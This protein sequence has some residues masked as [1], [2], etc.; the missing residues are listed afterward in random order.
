MAGMFSS[1]SSASYALQTHSRSVEQAG[2]NIANIN[3]PNYSRQRIVTGTIGTVASSTGVEAGPLV[4]LGVQQ[5]RDVYVDRQLLGELSYQ[6]SLETQDFRLRQALSNLGDSVD[7][8]SDALFVDDISQQGGGL[9]G[10]L[11]KFFN[12]FESLA[13]RPTDATT[14]QV[15]FQS[16]EALVDSFNRTDRRMELMQNELETQISVETT[17]FN[18]RISELEE[19]NREI[20]R[21]EL[22]LPGSALDLRD[23]RQ[24]KLEE[25][26]KYALVETV[27]APGDNGQISVGI[28]NDAGDLTQLIQP[29][30]GAK[31]IYFDSSART[32][33]VAG[34]GETL[35]IESGRLPALLEVRDTQIASV[36]SQLDLMASNVATEVNELYYQAFQPAT[37]SAPA[38]PEISFF[39]QPTPPPSVSGLPSTVTAASITLYSAPSD[40]SVTDYEALA[41][42]SLRAT[43]TTASGAN[44]LAL[45]LAGIGSKDLS[46]LGG[47]TLSEFSINTVTGLAQEIE[48]VQNRVE[49][50]DDV[51]LLLQTRRGEVSGVSMDEEVSQLLQYQRAFQASSRYFNV[52]SEMLETMINSL[53]R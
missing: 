14:R 25:L 8:T 37:G 26:S 34:S 1:L 33:R 28:R 2:K 15:V 41:S 29:G 4:A 19:L 5:V 50:Q 42:S 40:P 11:D 48:A 27:E 39:Q 53:G 47:M 51:V 31:E 18:Q 32:F 10:D 3:N 49:V 13:A 6:S 17:S 22:V 23:M 36:R 44:E 38:V 20:G 16:A 35:D 24:G 46:E 9:R 30:R 45:V 7:R 12:S 43:T 21:L 52:L